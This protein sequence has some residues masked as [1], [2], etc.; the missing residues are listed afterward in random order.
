VIVADDAVL[1]REGLAQILAGEGFEVV[2][3]AGNVDE[4]LA[5]VS[6]NRPDVVVLDIRMPPTQTDEGL[7]A[8]HA[9]RRSHPGVAV[10]I[11]SHYVDSSYSLQLL[12]E[13]ARG[14]GYLLKE[15]VGD[16]AELTEA[17]RRVARGGSVVDPEVVSRLMSRRSRWRTLQELTDREREVLKLMAEGRSNEAI[18]HRLRVGPKTVE[19]HVRNIFGKL[20]LEPTAD[21]HRRVLAVLTYLGA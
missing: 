3:Q 1:L 10:L 4:L 17:I 19:T 9:I 21:G 6:S 7:R 5:L 8:A 18:A 11:L 13:D 2:G 20:Q 12:A 16:I 15:R 14:L